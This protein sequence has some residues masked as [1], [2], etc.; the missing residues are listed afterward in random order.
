MTLNRIKNGKHVV[1]GVCQG[2]GEYFGLDPVLFRI[3]FVL[4]FIY[5][6]PAIIPYIILWAVLPKKTTFNQILNHGNN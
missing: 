1:G 4:L 6:F 2:L 5:P 3:A